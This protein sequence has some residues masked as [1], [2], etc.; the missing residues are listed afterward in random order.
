[1]KKTD[2]YDRR[3]PFLYTRGQESVMGL[4]RRFE[5][6]YALNGIA[7]VKFMEYNGLKYTMAGVHTQVGKMYSSQGVITQSLPN[8]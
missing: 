3:L 6:D 1:M 4:V 5:K 8:S 7:R 2:Y